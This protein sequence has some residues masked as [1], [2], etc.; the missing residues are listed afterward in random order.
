MKKQST[1][2]K[3]IAMLLVLTMVF[4]ACGSGSDSKD[5]TPTQAEEGG[6]GT[7]TTGEGEGTGEDG[8]PD[9]WIADRTVQVQAYVNDIGYA[10]PTDQLNTPVM[11]ELKKRTGMDIEF[12]YTPGE[13]DR[14]VLAAQLASGV[15]P[16]M[17]ISYLNDSS[18][19][20][21]PILHQASMDGM[22]AD[23]GPYLKEGSIY[24]KYYEEDYLPADTEG[25]IVF[26]EDFG[27][28]VYLVQLGMDAEDTSMIWDPEKEYKG[29]MYIQKAIADDLGIDV[30][31]INTSEKLYELL[32]Q[33]KEKDYKDVN[34][35]P[36]VAPLGPKYWGGSFDSAE[37]IMKDLWWGVSGFYNITEDG[38]ILHEA[39]T[40]WVFK[41]VEYVQ[42]L[43][44]EG[45]MHQEFFKMDETRAKEISK[46]QSVAIISDIHSYTDIIYESDAWI[47]LGP[48]VD[49]RGSEKKVTPGKTGSGVW[50]IPATAENPEEIVKLMD[51]LSTYE[52]QL[53]CKYGVEGVTYDMVEGFPV[54]KPEVQEA[55][56]T[57]DD[58]KLINEYGAAFNGSGV[59]GLE[60]I[61]T[62]MQSKKYFGESNVG[63]GS[64]ETFARA[65]EL[66]TD[67]PY[68]YELIPGLKANAFLPELEDVNTA[69]SLLDYNETRIQAFYAKSQDEVNGIIEGFRAQLK[70]AG[71]DK[72]YELVKSKYEANPELVQVY[73]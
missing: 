21:F 29:G 44:N 2:F 8:K 43:L 7:P 6:T 50:A 47:P 27:G 59:Y 26:R 39:E 40:D 16:D 30:K 46:N 51:Y 33:I 55:I 5:P 32:K 73:K 37:Y 65:V 71:I 62:N 52:G 60:F 19:P 49:F 23:I 12:L 64:N 1:K 72:F 41:Q 35:N 4:T 70:A 67:Y 61:L 9:T 48:I 36:L 38:N 25:N 54:L 11:K 57:G 58:T 22:F 63:A 15:L 14:F 3:L 56:N 18:R 45:L 20:E 10:L 17:I 31:S 34:G 66:A 42:K 69:V 68:E 53:L 28:A 13:K 24:S